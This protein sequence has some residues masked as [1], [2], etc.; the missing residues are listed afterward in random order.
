VL[1]LNFPAAQLVQNGAPAKLYFP[2]AQAV[3]ANAAAPL[4]VPAVQ[5]VQKGAPTSLYLPAAQ[6]VQ[7]DAP[8]PGPLKVPAL[9]GRHAAMEDPPPLGLYV[10]AAQLVQEVEPLPLNVPAAHREHTRVPGAT[11][12]PALQTIREAV[13]VWVAVPLGEADGERDGV[14]VP[15]HVG[16]PL[17]ELLKDV[18]TE[19]VGV[20]VAEGDG[21][22][23][24][25]GE[26]EG[27]A[28]MPGEAHKAG[29]GHG[30]HAEEK[31]APERAPKVPAGQR[32]QVELL[33][34]PVAFDHDPTAQGVQAV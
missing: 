31:D 27:A 13:G 28:A 22:P 14:T 32:V 25:V 11:Y 10:P 16:V 23:E 21:V 8:P 7:E 20:S 4:Y 17:G 1:G 24:L 18:F 19:G 29:H 12:Q 2:A 9:Q 30:T 5:L 15:L 33:E 34:A 3:Q 6:L 26:Q